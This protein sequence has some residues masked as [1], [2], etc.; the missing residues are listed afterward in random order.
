LLQS[1]GPTVS[2]SSIS[3]YRYRLV[4]SWLPVLPTVVFVLCNPSTADDETDDPTTRRCV[5]FARGWG[6]GSLEIVN[7]FAR[8]AVGPSALRGVADPVGPGND[9]AIRAAVA[10][11]A[12]VVAGWGAF[13][14]YQGRDRQVLA[15][16][17]GTPMCCLGRTR[18]GRPRHPL[19]APASTPLQ[20]WP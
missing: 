14:G 16:L 6:F 15:L 9:P 18:C 20:P 11:G 1:D 4:R 10:G 8:R 7:L 13:G 17:G 3:T 5:G 19:Y 12:L 2:E